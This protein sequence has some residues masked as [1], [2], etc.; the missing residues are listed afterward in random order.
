MQRII[1]FLLKSEYVFIPTT[2]T[3]EHPEP[4]LK[5]IHHGRCRASVGMELSDTL[6]FYFTHLHI[7]NSQS[8]NKSKGGALNN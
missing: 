4:A 8:I 2:Y 1:C 3:Q 7:Q 5:N 6:P